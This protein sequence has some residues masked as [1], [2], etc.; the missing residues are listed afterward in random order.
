MANEISYGTAERLRDPH[1]MPCN[2]GVAIRHST[3]F[4]HVNSKCEARNYYLRRSW[5]V[6]VVER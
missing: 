1:Y 2:A 5:C 4:C 6:T 3:Y